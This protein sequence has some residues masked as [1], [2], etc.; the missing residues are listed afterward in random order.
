[1]PNYR[2]FRASSELF[3]GYT[4]FIDIDIHNSLNNIINHFYEH[5][6]HTLE[7]N[8]FEILIEKVNECRFHI[9]DFTYEDIKNLNSENV[10]YICDHCSNS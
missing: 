5:L 7:M 6:L 9:H 2:E 10:Y 8:N 1:M 4:V 3:L